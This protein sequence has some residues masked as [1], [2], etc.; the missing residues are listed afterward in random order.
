VNGDFYLNVSNGDVYQKAAGAWGSPVGNIKGPTGAAGSGGSSGSNGPGL[1]TG[2]RLTITSGTPY[3]TAAFTLAQT[4][5]Y[6]TPA[7]G[8][9]CLLYDGTNMIPTTFTEYSQA[10]SDTSKSPAAT[11]NTSNYDI[12]AWN[13]GGTFRVT[14]G[15]AWTNQTTRGAGTALVRV[16]GVLLNNASITNGP[17]AQRGTYVGTISTDGANKLNM[18]FSVITAGGGINRLDVWNMYNREEIVSVNIDTTASWTYSLAA[19][20]PK[21]GTTNNAISW[22]QGIDDVG[23]HA[24]QC[25]HAQQ[26][27]AALI[28]IGFGLDSSTTLATE[29]GT[30]TLGTTV[31][32]KVVSET[33]E[34]NTRVAAGWHYICPLEFATASGVTTWY[35]ATTIGA[36]SVPLWSTFALRLGM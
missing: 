32:G 33:L 13:D 11:A 34:F 16:K 31:A 9:T 6:F 25:Q 17:A 26:A 12:F 8:D 15:P 3:L 1:V 18:M 14:R 2:G 24:S 30:A 22:V 36:G 23:V 35:G 27:N 28:A 7:T 20:A 21:N 5:L 4:T 29:C 10:L 19:W